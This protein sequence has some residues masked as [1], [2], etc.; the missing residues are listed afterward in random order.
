M[1]NSL[2]VVLTLGLLVLIAGCTSLLGMYS[3]HS[4]SDSEVDGVFD[5]FDSLIVDE[6][7]DVELGSII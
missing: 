1:N 6:T 2:V 4:M 5:D 3:S 7:D